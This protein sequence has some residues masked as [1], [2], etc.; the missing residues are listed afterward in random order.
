MSPP[1]RHTHT[2]LPLR[3]TQRSVPSSYALFRPKEIYTQIFIFI[4]KFH[5]QKKSSLAK[6]GLVYTWITTLCKETSNYTTT[7]QS[8]VSAHNKPSWKLFVRYDV[9]DKNGTPTHYQLFF[10]NDAQTRILL[11]NVLLRDIQTR[12]NE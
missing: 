6:R 10:E 12:Q 9:H 7:G 11:C 4:K 3:S 5:D 8:L 2:E 1:S